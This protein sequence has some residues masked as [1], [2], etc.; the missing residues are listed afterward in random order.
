MSKLEDLHLDAMWCS[1][2]IVEGMH[3][4]DFEI[5]ARD[6]DLKNIIPV[7]LDP[8]E[9]EAEIATWNVSHNPPPE[10]TMDLFDAKDPEAVKANEEKKAA[11]KLVAAAKR[12]DATKKKPKKPAKTK[13][14][15]SVGKRKRQK[16]SL[17]PP[18]P[19]FQDSK[20]TN[21]PP[22]HILEFS[23][24]GEWIEVEYQHMEI[25][26][27]GD[28]LCAVLEVGTN[29][30]HHIL[31]R[32]KNENEEWEDANDW[33]PLFECDGCGGNTRGHV[34][35]EECGLYRDGSTGNSSDEE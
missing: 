32:E 7:T 17:S 13:A 12:K 19:P 27:E 4:S 21:P 9:L 29:D 34:L 33:E 25:D 31:L 1:A 6:M 5:E 3:K 26:D 16:K 28:E 2:Q 20:A 10:H 15:P 30:I 35:C 23:W 22:G 11:K 14:K 8:E 24:D 18:P